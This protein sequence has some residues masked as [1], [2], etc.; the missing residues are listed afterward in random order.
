MRDPKVWHGQTT[1]RGTRI[2]VSVILDAL[3]DRMSEAE[4]EAEYPT[5]TAAG[6]RAAAYGAEFARDELLGRHGPV[7]IKLDEN[8]PESAALHWS[9]RATTPTGW[10]PKASAGPTTRSR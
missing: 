6:I 8:R 3:A 4:I 5:W 10:S 1:V 9:V 7:T 2:M